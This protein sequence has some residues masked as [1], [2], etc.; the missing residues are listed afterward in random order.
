[1]VTRIPISWLALIPMVKCFS[2]GIRMTNMIFIDRGSRYP[3]SRSIEYEPL[4]KTN[5]LLYRL[6][7]F[8]VCIQPD[9]VID[10][11]PYTFSPKLSRH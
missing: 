4:A 2:E 1:M 11:P 7:L 5:E 6:F 8:C 10:D 3:S 9:L